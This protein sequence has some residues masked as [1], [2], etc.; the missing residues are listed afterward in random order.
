MAG[1]INNLIK[2]VQNQTEIY[3]QLIK[4][5][6]N[7]KEA[8]VNN[9]IEKVQQLTDDESLLV[10]KCNKYNKE[11]IEL[12]KDIA[13]VLNKNPDELTLSRILVLIEGQE[14]APILAKLRDETE[15]LLEELKRVNDM[16]KT[17]VDFSLEHLEFSMNVFR[18]SLSRQPSYYD[19]TGK[20]INTSG[21]SFFDAKQ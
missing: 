15:A 7:K 12:F 17:L 10:G 6:L 2:N 18:Q 19:S 16:N 8:I 5:G 14:E 21:N 9:D 20:E 13:F 11:R 4:T 3:S 1:L